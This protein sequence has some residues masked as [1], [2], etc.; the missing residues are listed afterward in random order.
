MYYYVSFLS[1]LFKRP[2]IEGL[3]ECH[4]DFIRDAHVKCFLNLSKVHL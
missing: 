4:P 2:K 1:I 3:L